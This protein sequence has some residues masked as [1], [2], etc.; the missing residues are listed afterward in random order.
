MNISELLSKKTYRSITDHLQFPPTPSIF[1]TKNK[2]FVK[3]FAAFIKEYEVLYVHDTLK[4]QISELFYLKNPQYKEGSAES[5]KPLEKFQQ[6]YV[7]KS[8]NYDN[9]GTWVY[10][11]WTKTLLHT[12]DERD[13]F[14]ARTYRN[15]YLITPEEQ[16]KLYR[17][18]IG[19]A[20]LS[21]GNSVALC[22]AYSGIGGT[23][24]LADPDVFSVSN[25]NRVRVPLHYVGL[26]KVYV[27]A[28]Q[29]YEVNPYAKLVL[30]PEGVTKDTIK[31]FLIG[32][33]KLDI[34]IDEMDQ[35]KMKLFIRLAARAIKM[36]VLMA[37]DNGDNGI[38]DVDRFDLDQKQGPFG[39]LPMMDLDTVIRGIDFGESFNLTL[40]EKIR[41]SSK[42][43]GPEGVAPRMQDSLK[44]VG[45]T[46]AS[47][48]QL[49]ISAFLG[50][51][52]A[53]Y[54]A[55][56]LLLGM[57]IS[58]GKK[59]VSLDEIFLDGYM[60][61]DSVKKRKEK[62]NEF[63]QYINSLEAKVSHPAK[64]IDVHDFPVKKSISAKIQF[65][66]EYAIL[67]PSTH[68]T[69]PWIFHIDAHSLFITPDPERILPVSD[70]T[71]REMYISL[72]AAL[73]NVLIAAGRFDLSTNVSFIE[74]NGDCMIRVDFDNKKVS[75]L[76]ELFNQ[77]EMRFTD[78]SF[79][80]AHK[81][82]PSVLAEIRKLSIDSQCSLY[83]VD[84]EKSKGALA[85]ELASASRNIM[86]NAAFRKELAFWIRNNFTKLHDGF[87]IGLPD[88]QSL[89]APFL[90]HEFNLESPT[91]ESR[92][93]LMLRHSSGIVVI[94]T[95]TDVVSDWI[96]AGQLYERVVLLL[97]TRG[98][99]HSIH[100]AMIE[101][102]NARK[103][104]ATMLGTLEKPQVFLRIGYSKM[105]ITHSPRRN[106]KE[107]LR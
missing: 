12:L 2:D 80:A 16:K 22:L 86:K 96:K 88:I 66:L 51:V 17:A 93:A 62:T 1:P 24:K 106:V 104:L 85:K 78:R 42:I 48:P 76:P 38:I 6:K 3:K 20:G 7:G 27:A 49:G 60:N 39:Q 54:N 50:G 41:L 57:P 89:L 36:P 32:S 98:V 34:V 58:S 92:E 31:D 84:D 63:I 15:R 82:Q 97:G 37:T 23:L 65:L 69:Q 94:A 91:E 11:P 100:A 25:L 19:I 43:V 52:N 99:H 53:A 73:E 71:K 14:E 40:D 55:K 33:A 35:L 70:P 64:R 105:P 103:T 26:K 59:Y 81:I 30:Y 13:Y 45:S 9:A 61:E 67:A 4:D 101:E 95:K 75:Y 79:F 90:M 5:L 83:F 56:A 10:Y 102:N 107:T 46:I 28:Q 72:G 74:K 18:V 77:I 47:W 44:E 8:S 21:V 29:I 68:N 87:S